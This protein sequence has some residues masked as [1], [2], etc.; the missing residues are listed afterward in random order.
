[1]EKKEKQEKLTLAELIDQKEKV[2]ARK[3]QTSEL[4]I[5][6]LGGTVTVQAP[7]PSLLADVFKM[8]DG[9]GDK[10]LVFQSVAEPCLKD[11][12]VMEAYGASDP[13]ELMDKLFM[14][15]EITMIAAECMKLAGYGAGSVT[16]A[17]QA[18]KVKN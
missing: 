4:Y 11:G 10:Y 2:L 13:L 17:E 14:P 12:G 8:Q 5:K 18:E 7:A 1:M 16:K 3:N 9:E 15:G 6:G